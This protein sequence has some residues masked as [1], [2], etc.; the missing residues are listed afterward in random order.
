MTNIQ[1]ACYYILICHNTGLIIA[2]SMEDFLLSR[3][4]NKQ[5]EEYIAKT[6]FAL[7][8]QK[9]YNK[10]TYQKI[11]DA[12][13]NERT[14]VQL[15]FPKKELLIIEFLNRLLVHSIQYIDN[16]FPPM[17]NSFVKLYQ[18]GQIYFAFLIQHPNLTLEIF[19]DRTITEKILFL[20]EDWAYAFLNMDASYKNENLTEDIVMSMGGAYELIY[21]N[22]TKG[23]TINIPRLLR[24]VV[25]SFMSSLGHERNAAETLLAMHE[26]N[27]QI[28]SQSNSRLITDLLIQTKKEELL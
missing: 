1:I 2:F 20:N 26:L 21:R 19:A 24:K 3:Q 10:T 6:A 12:T 5:N 27:E 17:E 11:A 14:I 18:I 25:V 22:I 16:C 23:D 15:Y 7:F 28:F 4:K 8:L 13:D 9:G